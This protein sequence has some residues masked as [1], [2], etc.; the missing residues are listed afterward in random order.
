MRAWPVLLLCVWC[1]PMFPGLSAGVL[2]HINVAFL[3]R[4]AITARS[5]WL[6]RFVVCRESGALFLDPQQRALLHSRC[7]EGSVPPTAGPLSGRSTRA[8]QGGALAPAA[9]QKGS[10]LP[11]AFFLPQG[12]TQ[13]PP[14]L[15][16]C[17][18]HV[19]L[20]I[21]GLGYSRG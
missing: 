2:R 1:M 6:D 9:G 5:L 4:N 8:S 12:G 18:H 10:Y 14:Y 15:A 3:R 20:C 21:F 13:K 17:R 16:V 7:E 11:A 19:S